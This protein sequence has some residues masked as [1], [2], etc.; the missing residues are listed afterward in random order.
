VF[1]HEGRYGQF[2]RSYSTRFSVGGATLTYLGLGNSLRVSVPSTVSFNCVEQYM[3]YAKA[4]CFGDSEMASAILH[5]GL[6]WKHRQFSQ[7]VKGYDVNVWK[8]VQSTVLFFGNLT[9]FVARYD[10]AMLLASTGDCPLYDVGGSLL[11]GIGVGEPRAREMWL[12]GEPFEGENLQGQAL[13][14]VRCCIRE[15]LYRGLIARSP[16]SVC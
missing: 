16:V 6:R 12:L 3:H 13:E 9:R 7:K 5:T 1:F 2:C 4:V 15:L 8:G 11:W 10:D 14:R